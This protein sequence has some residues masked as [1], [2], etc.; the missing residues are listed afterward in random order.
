MAKHAS[1]ARAEE[2]ED[3]DEEEEEE[4]EGL[5]AFEPIEKVKLR[6][7]NGFRR[8]IND[9][10]AR[11]VLLFTAGSVAGSVAGDAA[12]QAFREFTGYNP[13][14]AI[15][16]VEK[17]KAHHKIPK[18]EDQEADGFL[19]KAKQK[20]GDAKER[21]KEQ[22][23]DMVQQ[24]ALFQEYQRALNEIEETYRKAI[25]F[26][27]KASYWLAFLLA[28]SAVVIL[29]NKL[30]Q[31]KKTLTENVDPL[32]EKNMKKMAETINQLV[33]TVNLLVESRTNLTPEMIGKIKEVARECKEL[34]GKIK[35]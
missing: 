14:Q 26:S 10:L 29:G 28:L 7:V 33:G 18:K 21:A 5:E 24:S 13:K 22:I 1:K 4:E 23:K 27:D 2:D 15:V 19:A 9:I 3:L 31:A 8:K 25:E 30:I 11:T 6:A 17:G 32:V 34:S 35:K 12:Q 16:K 20:L